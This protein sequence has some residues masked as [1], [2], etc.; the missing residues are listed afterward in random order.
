MVHSRRCTPSSATHLAALQDFDRQVR[1]CFAAL[2][3]LHLD[4]VQ[5][6]QAARGL[7]LGGLSLRLAA[8]DSSAAYL[9][10]VGGSA[11]LCGELDPSYNAITDSHAASALLSY[12]HNFGTGA[13]LTLDEALA[14]T[15]KGLSLK[16]DQA[17]LRSHLNTAS[18]VTKAVLLS[19]CEPGA[20]AFLNAV[21]RGH[22]QME[23]AIFITELGQRLGVA[24]AVADGWCPKCD[25]VMD[26]FSHHAAV[27]LENPA[28]SCYPRPAGLVA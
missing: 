9:A 1:G 27:C 22:T 25:A 4:G 17:S 19:E 21:P 11:Q 6:E 28:T 8:R 26:R 2:T 20:R 5:W 3:G 15:Q 14:N 18:V 12:N 16:L 10:S 7:A 13:G 23:P 24:D